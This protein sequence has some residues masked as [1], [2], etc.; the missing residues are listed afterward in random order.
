[1]HLAHKL[2]AMI[3]QN[4]LAQASG[5]LLAKGGHEHTALLDDLAN[6]MCAANG[7]AANGGEALHHEVI[8]ADTAATMR[9]TRLALEASAWIKR[10]VQGVLKRG[11]DG[12][13]GEA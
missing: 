7:S 11:A 5:F 3:L 6:V 13:R 12:E 2:P 4:G 9:L 10:Y 8:T 1:M